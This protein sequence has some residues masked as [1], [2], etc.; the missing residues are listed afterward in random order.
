MT[1]KNSGRYNIF[2]YM[3]LICTLWIVG[4]WHIIGY[5]NDRSYYNVI[6]TPFKNQ[7]TYGVLAAFTFIS[8][9]L[10]YRNY[11]SIKS[12]FCY[13]AKKL[14]RL[15]PFFVLSCISLVLMRRMPI[16]T[17]LPDLVG[18][19]WVIQPFP[20][21]VWFAGMIMI[22]YFLNPFISMKNSLLSCIISILIW[23]LFFV[24]NAIFGTDERMWFYWIYFVLGSFC[25]RFGIL[26]YVRG[27]LTEIRSYCLGEKDTMNSCKG[28]L[29]ENYVCGG[30]EA[31]TWY[32]PNR[33]QKLPKTK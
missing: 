28:R 5:L 33:L 15:Y 26:E 32:T 17:L 29:S 16:E 2:D 11:D 22:F 3:R 10:G 20:T 9:Y 18:L 4:I 27:I 24:L 30:G 1:D 6:D 12:I 13:Y 31:V 21:T 7:L 14:L 25:N 23:I 19:G 8:G